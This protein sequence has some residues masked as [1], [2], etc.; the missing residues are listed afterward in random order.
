M[1][2]PISFSLA[3]FAFAMSFVTPAYAEA[4]AG[5]D[6]GFASLIPL[7]LIMVI[8]YF[9]LIRPQQKKLKDHRNMVDSLKKGDKVMTGGGIYGRITAVND[10][11]VKVE[12]ASGVIIKVSRDTVAGLAEAAVAKTD[13]PAKTNEAKD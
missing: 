8:F 5:A 12:I 7:L 11:T 4:A 13:K 6:G 2:S 9:L 10:D 3:S 1:K